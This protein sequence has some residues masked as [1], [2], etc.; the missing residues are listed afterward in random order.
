MVSEH[1]R[2]M[3]LTVSLSMSRRSLWREIRD[4]AYR[5]RRRCRE[6]V[7]QSVVL[8]PRKGAIFSAAKPCQTRS[9]EVKRLVLRGLGNRPSAKRGRRRG[10]PAF[11]DGCGD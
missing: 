7:I 2:N 5:P 1:C 8:S 10:D 4:A 11:C 6:A 9:R 3:A